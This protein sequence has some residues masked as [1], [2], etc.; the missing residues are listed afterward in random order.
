MIDRRLSGNSP[1]G[2]RVV[3]PIVRTGS[4]PIDEKITPINMQIVSRRASIDVAL[5]PAK[6]KEETEGS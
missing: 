3:Y 1:I 5:K 2:T 6:A 4:A